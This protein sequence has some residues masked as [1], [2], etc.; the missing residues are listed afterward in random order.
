M[1]LGPTG[2]GKTELARALAELMFDDKDALIRIDMSEYMEWFSS[3]RL[4]GAP[5]GYVGY[6][7][8]GQLTERVRRRPY[9]VVLFDEIEKAHPEIFNM[10]LQ[11]LDDGMLTDSLGRK[12]DFKNTVLIMTSNVGARLIDKGAPLGFQR[13]HQGEQTK[14]IK[15]TVMG[16]LKKTFNPE[17]LNRL[18]EVV[19]FHQ[20]TK[21]HLVKIVDILI[22]EVNVRLA[23]QG[24][25]LA[26]TPEVKQWLIDEGYQP[27]YGAR[28]MRRC[29]QRNIEDQLSEEVLRGRFK[30]AGKDKDKD[31]EL[32]RIKVVLKDN[33]PAFVTE[34][35]LAGV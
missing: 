33:S 2:V 17:F 28:P 34:E 32:K 31:K 11:V 26:L 19:V 23:E 24:L 15:E 8:G 5:P 4:V 30:E 10:L 13:E 27:T 1:F 9:S 3:S 14:Q 6:E 25:Y 7:E 20:L 35:A 16:E 21:E 29:I 18:D 12:V 22:G